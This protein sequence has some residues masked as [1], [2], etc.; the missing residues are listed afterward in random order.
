[1]IGRCD[2][3]DPDTTDEMVGAA[4]EGVCEPTGGFCVVHRADELQ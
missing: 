1:M 3:T 2:A 4:P